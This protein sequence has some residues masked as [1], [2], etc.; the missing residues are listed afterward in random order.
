MVLRHTLA[1]AGTGIAFGILLGIGATVLLR[2]QFY[3]IS[4]VEW[5]VLVPVGAA[6]LAVSLLVAYLSARSWIRVDPMAAVRHV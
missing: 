4:A 2:S 3:G 1:I 5:T 6:M